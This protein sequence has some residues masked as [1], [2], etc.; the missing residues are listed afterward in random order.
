MKWVKK[1][2]IFSANKNSKHMV[3]GGRAPVPLHLEG[4]IFR[5]YFG[6]F[7]ELG[8]GRIYYLELNITNPNLVLNVSTKP[9]LDIGNIGYY[10]D[11][12]IIPSDIVEVNNKI[13]LYTI[14]FSQKNKIIFDASSGLA[15]STD[16]GISF[17]KLTGPILNASPSDPCW[18]ASP[19]VIKESELW[20]MWYVSCDKW[21]K[22]N[23]NYKHYYNIK[24]KTSED[25][26]NWKPESNV[27]ID[28]QN[29]FEYA[30]SRPSVLKR[31][32][33]YQM[34]YSYRGQKNID[35]YRIG[36]AESSNGVNWTRKDNLVGIDV[37]SHGWDSEMICYPYVFIHNNEIFMVYNG[38]GYGRSGFGIAKLEE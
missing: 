18:A 17:D 4:D 22:E 36:Y 13:F 25:G 2:L 33:K 21:L 31:D 12:G 32:D 24:H 38:N 30:I 16:K 35:T 29:D 23:D 26:V 15:I 6:S 8:R 27:C 11:N 5:F 20:H 1:G 34:W 10:D 3:S 37:S 28:Y 14:G 9:L 19:F 7:D